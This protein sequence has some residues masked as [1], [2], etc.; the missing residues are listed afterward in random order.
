MSNAEKIQA[1][2]VIDIK[3][4][5][6]IGHNTDLIGFLKSLFPFIESHH[7][8]ALILGTGGAGQSYSSRFTIYGH[9]IFIC[10]Q[11]S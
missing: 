9:R 3:D 1:V 2:N 5:K 8:K 4:G 10:I 11:R 7:D 6:L